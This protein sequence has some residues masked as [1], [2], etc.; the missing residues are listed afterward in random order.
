MSA[1]PV[2]TDGITKCIVN[3]LADAFA[4]PEFDLD[5]GMIRFLDRDE[6]CIWLGLFPIDE[7][8]EPS[9]DPTATWTVE[10]SC[11]PK[12]ANDPLAE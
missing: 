5:E 8:G 11:E 4:D 6:S 7:N 1:T 3:S 12:A 9:T 2:R 10:V